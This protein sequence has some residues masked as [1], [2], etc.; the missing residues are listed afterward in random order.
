M[1]NNLDVDDDFCHLILA[2]EPTLAGTPSRFTKEV[3]M[4]VDHPSKLIQ[5]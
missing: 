3:A 5:L 1:S 2:S 4:D